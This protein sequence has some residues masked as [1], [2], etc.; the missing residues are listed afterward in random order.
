MHTAGQ[1]EL[2]ST[3]SLKKDFDRLYFG[4]SGILSDICYPHRPDSTELIL[5]AK[6]SSVQKHGVTLKTDGN[7]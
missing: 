3:F 6:D 1:N 4:L 5:Q 2:I 7:S